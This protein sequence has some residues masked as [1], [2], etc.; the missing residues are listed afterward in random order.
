[1]FKSKIMSFLNLVIFIAVPVVFP[2]DSAAQ[3]PAET[4]A[5]LQA[6]FEQR[7]FSA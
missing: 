4:E 5:R 1:M 7:E 2:V 3:I 6:I